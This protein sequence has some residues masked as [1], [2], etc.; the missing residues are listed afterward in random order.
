MR[1]IKISSIFKNVFAYNLNLNFNDIPIVRRSSA[2]DSINLGSMMFPD[3]VDK[4][5]RQKAPRR[6]L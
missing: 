1:Y 4:N 2:T 3:E 5:T 6:I